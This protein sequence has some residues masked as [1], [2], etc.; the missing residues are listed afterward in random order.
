M[1]L[2]DLSREELIEI[3]KKDYIQIKKSIPNTPFKE[4]EYY[5]IEQD[6]GGISLIDDSGK[7]W[8]I[9]NID[10]EKYLKS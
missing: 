5:R 9:Y 1:I 7:W 6:E 8:D 3:I 10:G 4:G 2:E